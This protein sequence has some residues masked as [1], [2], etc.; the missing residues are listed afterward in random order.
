MDPDGTNIT[1]MTELNILKT[2]LNWSSDGRYLVFEGGGDIYRL[3]VETREVIKVVTF[4]ESNEST[5]VLTQ[6][7]DHII[8]SSDRTTNWNLYAAD[9]STSDQLNLAQITEG[10]H[11]D[12]SFSWYS[13]Q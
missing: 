1:Q 11:L 7:E 13:C 12:R 9:L 4:D 5:P 8:F 2:G 6:N 10:A 3:D